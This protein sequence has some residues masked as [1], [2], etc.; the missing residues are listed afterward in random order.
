MLDALLDEVHAR[1]TQD[2]PVLALVELQPSTDTLSIGL[3]RDVSVLNYVAGSGDPP[4]FTSSGGPD[5]E[6]TVHYRYMG[7]WSEYPTKNT[8]P[9]AAARRAMRHFW[10][11]GELDPSVAWEEV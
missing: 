10:L 3:G 7:D 1:A 11:T 8:I 2:E 6:E 4:Y 9:M 5:S